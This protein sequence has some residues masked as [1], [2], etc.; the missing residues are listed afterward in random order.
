MPFG[1]VPFDIGLGN[2]FAYG[3]TPAM[4]PAWIQSLDLSTVIGCSFRL[5]LNQT[6]GAI[7][8]V[9]YIGTPPTYQAQSSTFVALV[10]DFTGVDF[11]GV[12]GPWWISPTLILPA[13]K[14]VECNPDYLVVTNPYGKA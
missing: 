14:S 11:G 13:G 8:W 9:G 3:C 6:G 7:S 5:S 10:H 2:S 1:P 12:T 4:L